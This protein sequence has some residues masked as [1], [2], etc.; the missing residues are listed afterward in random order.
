[1]TT[2]AALDTALDNLDTHIHHQC[3]LK[4]EDIVLNIFSEHPL[5]PSKAASKAEPLPWSR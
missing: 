4:C 1:M 5:L 2:D 3:D